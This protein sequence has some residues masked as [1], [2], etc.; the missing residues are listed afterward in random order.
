MLGAEQLDLPATGLA[1]A[2]DVI[3]HVRRLPGGAGIAATTLV[4]VNL[5]QVAASARV[6]P[7]DEVALLPP[8][9]GG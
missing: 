3:A 5:K 1:T 2:G 6:A 8:L 9:A 4:A 7:G